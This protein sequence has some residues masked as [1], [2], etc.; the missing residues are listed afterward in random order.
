[1]T[2]A[3]ALG[4]L[5]ARAGVSGARIEGDPDTLVGGIVHDDRQVEAGDV[6]CCLRG[7]RVDGHDL[8]PAAV[9]AGAAALVVE[10]LLGLGVPEVVVPSARA[11][12]A[13]LAAAR[14]DDPSHHLAVV[15]V[16]GTS[17]KTTTTHVLAAILD[18]HGWSC[19][20]I[21]TLTGAF[22]TPESPEL[23]ARLA[24]LRA[25]GARAVAMEVS[26][27]ALAQHRVDATRFAVAVFTN[28]SQDH[29]DFHG[30][31]ERYFAAKARLFE[32]DLTERAVVNLDDPHG[33]LLMDAALVPTRGYSSSEVRDLELTPS[34]ARFTWP[35]V[36]ARIRLGLGGGFNVA[37]AL[38]AGTA[39]LELGVPPATVAA[40]LEAAGPVP[41]RFEAVEAGQPFTVVVDYAHKPGGLRAVL[42]TARRLTDGSVIVVF[43]AGGDRDR[44]KRPLMGAAAAE[45]ADVVVVTSDNPRREDPST[46]IDAVMSGIRPGGRADGDDLGRARPAVIVEPDR[47]AAIALAL[48]R[49]RPGDVVVVAGKG[50]ETTQ[51]IGDEVRP[52]DDRVVARELLEGR[53]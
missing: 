19:G 10:R 30:T 44:E 33:Q 43:G 36:G 3:V 24:A 37:N 18:A 35:A 21:G 47:R 2:P 13:R 1:M 42:D 31:M 39:A 8:A 14:F 53:A 38:A 7:E 16:T 50:H 29:L 23:Q 34:S 4:P 11:A 45:G 6:F 46:I 52:F 32:P 15:G 48:D 12:M 40:G 9:A 17:G 20:V 5:V 26:S 41:G 27:H 51:T 25:E 28:L 22:T 49:A